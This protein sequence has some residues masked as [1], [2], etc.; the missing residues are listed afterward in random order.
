[1]GSRK[2]SARRRQAEAFR[3]S[4]G[5]DLDRAYERAAAERQAAEGRREAAHRAK[6]CESKNRYATQWDAREAIDWCAAQ[7][8]TGLT[9]Y[10][11]EFCD[12]WHLTS[13]PRR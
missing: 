8:R 6:A 2:P 1:M 12:G 10:R 4:L 13:H 7:G 5:D 9:C 3:L 11:C